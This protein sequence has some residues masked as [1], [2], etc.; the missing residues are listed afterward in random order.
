M[1]NTSPLEYV[2]LRF[3]AIL[4]TLMNCEEMTE[5]GPVCSPMGEYVKNDAMRMQHASHAF[6][7][8]NIKNPPKQHPREIYTSS[9]KIDLKPRALPY[10]LPIPIKD[11]RD[12]THGDR[13]ERQQRV[14]P[15]EAE[16]RVH[17]LPGQR[18]Q[19]ADEGAQDSVGGEGGGGV[20]GEG[21]DEVGLDGHEG[22]EEAEADE[23]GAQDGDQPEDVLLG[24]PAIE[25]YFLGWMR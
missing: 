25:E 24:R 13:D 7:K 14:P 3:Y 8:H 2:R 19:G 18:Q 4:W 1:Q 21:V 6:P 12:R 10:P 15:S 9:L 11:D 5:R 17:L 23:A 22:G 20:D 16:R